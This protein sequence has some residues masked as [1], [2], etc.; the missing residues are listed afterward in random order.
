MRSSISG[1][2]SAARRRPRG[3]GAAQ[4]R[5]ASR[6]A[7]SSEVAARSWAAAAAAR[8][9]ARA[10]TSGTSAR[11][12]HEIEAAALD[13]V[14]QQAHGVIAARAAAGRIA[15]P[16]QKAREL[17]HGDEIARRL[18]GRRAKPRARVAQI[19]EALVQLTAADERGQAARRIALER[20]ELLRD[21]ERALRVAGL[22][23]EVR[24]RRD[25][26]VV[27]G[28]GVQHTRVGADGALGVGD[29]PR[30]DEAQAHEHLVQHLG[31]ALDDGA[32]QV[33]L[34]R[35]DVGAV[36]VLEIG[37]AREGA[38][39][40]RLLL[41][42]G[43]ELG[44]G[45]A[46]VPE[47]ARE[48]LGAREPQ[49]RDLEGVARGGDARREGL[50]EHGV[51]AVLLE[52]RAQPREGELVGGLELEDLSEQAQRAHVAMRRRRRR[53]VVVARELGGA[54]QRRHARG[55]AVQDARLHGAGLDGRA[56]IA[57]PRGG[58]AQRHHRRQVLG[59][60]AERGA[61]ATR[62]VSASAPSRAW[63]AAAPRQYV[64]ARDARRR[65]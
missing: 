60:G 22:D 2:A 61:Q 7:A 43:L 45:A 10:G 62:R 31:R 40:L 8:A 41:Q 65:R 19:A 6:S 58:P 59:I 17:A 63:A 24:Q 39:V 49:R 33:E 28:L 12:V 46:P 38:R 21:G 1:R 50:G 36:V 55:P 23:V 9:F 29:V 44:L 34:A 30:V 35:L 20:R 64:A 53:R 11:S 13:V 37:Q 5:A 57:R 52:E 32:P 16:L 54:Q 3:G 27:A 15:R 47:R 56:E 48:E 51:G 26:L 4:P 18:V 25:G 14:A 42:D